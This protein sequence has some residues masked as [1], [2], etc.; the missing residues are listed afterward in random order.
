MLPCPGYHVVAKQAEGTRTGKEGSTSTEG[1]GGESTPFS[2][3][4]LAAP[5]AGIKKHALVKLWLNET[6]HVRESQ[7]EIKALLQDAANV[8]QE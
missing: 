3:K 4:Q 5:S 2:F 1:E 7:E 6:A 8:A